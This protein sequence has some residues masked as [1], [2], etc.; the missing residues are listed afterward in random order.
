MELVEADLRPHVAVGRNRSRADQA[1]VCVHRTTHAPDDVTTRDGLRITTPLRTVLDLARS[2]PLSEAVA[3]A[4]SALRRGL[5]TIAELKAGLRRMP[6]G[7]G[8]SRVARVLAM[9]DPA[10][11]SVLESLC[12]VLFA[13]RG[14]PA[15]VTQHWVRATGW[16]GRVDFAWPERRLVVET[17]G[18]AF[19]SDRTTFRLDRRRDNALQREGWRVVRVT[20]EDVLRAPDYVVGLVTA[21]M[22]DPVAA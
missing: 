13:L 7:P 11:G 9:V 16:S 3:A 20:Y 22:A 17:D 8:R 21:M 6:N 14:L 1:G 4:D 15:P 5:L 10:S 19:H 2:L 12:R 18:F